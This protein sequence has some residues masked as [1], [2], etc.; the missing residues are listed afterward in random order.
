MT[1]KIELAGWVADV[2]IVMS[3]EVEVERVESQSLLYNHL[4]L[5]TEREKHKLVNYIS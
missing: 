2:F 4:E 3:I 1:V 5:N